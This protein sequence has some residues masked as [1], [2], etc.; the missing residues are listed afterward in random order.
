MKRASNQNTEV[1]KDKTDFLKE[2][3]KFANNVYEHSVD[4]IH[5]V[6]DSVKE[7]S[8]KL[9]EGVKLYP[10]TTALTTALIV[11]GIILLVSLLLRKH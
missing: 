2:G 8:E 10:K 1:F 5:D 7:Y 11:G 6:E 9:V 3:K 4:A